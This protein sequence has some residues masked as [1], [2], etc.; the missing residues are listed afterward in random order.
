MKNRKALIVS[1]VILFLFSSC[2]KESLI[3]SSELTSS[4]A[5]SS[6]IDVS[7]SVEVTYSSEY[8]WIQAYYDYGMKSANSQYYLTILLVD[9]NFDGIPELLRG[10]YSDGSYYFFEGLS[11]QNGTVIPLQFLNFTQLIGTT[12]DENGNMLWYGRHYPM[13]LH[14]S[15][16]TAQRF[17]LY[18]FS[19]F[20]NIKITEALSISF[21][22]PNFYSRENSDYLEVTVHSYGE[23]LTLTDAE[24]ALYK[25]WYASNATYNEDLN[26]LP[27]LYLLENNL[28]LTSQKNIQIELFSCYVDIDGE[29]TLD[30][31]LFEKYLLQW[32]AYNENEFVYIES[33]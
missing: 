7:S 18:D 32:Y 10:S 6:T 30:L 12:T 22:L 9:L 11:Y 13:A 21:F 2:K 20:T 28:S 25:S 24:Y 27:H 19:D 1:I 33:L 23:L 15:P 8:A 16:G 31:F 29:R 17:Y 14:R 3:T 5:S 4:E 26:K